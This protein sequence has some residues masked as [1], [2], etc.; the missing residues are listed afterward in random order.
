[1]NLRAII[2]IILCKT[3]RLVSRLLHRGGT[4][5]PGRWALKVC[6]NLLA[7]LLLSNV[8]VKDTNKYLW[9][10]RLDEEE[11]PTMN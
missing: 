9:G 10:G 4:A 1:M 6:P 2:A 3:L 5:M 8:L 11:K 7:L